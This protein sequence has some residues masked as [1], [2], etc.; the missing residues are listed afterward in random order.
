[1]SQDLT[2]YSEAK[3]ERYGE[4]LFGHV[5][6]TA[7]VILLDTVGDAP[8]LC[9][10]EPSS[11][12]AGMNRGYWQ[13]AEVGVTDLAEGEV[14]VAKDGDLSYF[15]KREVETV[16]GLAARGY[17]W[18]L[19]VVRKRTAKQAV[20][21]PLGT[22]RNWWGEGAG[23]N[24]SDYE[25]RWGASGNRTIFSTGKT[26][27]EFVN[28]YVAHAKHPRLT[29]LVTEA[30]AWDTEHNR[31]FRVRRE[32]RDNTLAPFTATVKMANTA[33][34]FNVLSVNGY[35][36][37]PKIERAYSFEKVPTDA[38]VL[39]LEARVLKGE[40]TTKVAEQVRKALTTNEVI[41]GG[42]DPEDDEF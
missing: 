42:Y 21:S 41:E 8:V 32:E 20:V 14:I 11:Y 27:A 23:V 35:G 30:K 19:Y 38:L 9:E 5:Q 26:L 1:M 33:L 36:D 24:V 37:Q 39:M 2:T 12:R 13:A 18:S 16:G 7:E 6:K 34:G 31:R 40:V 3:F 25:E 15:E 4:A 17:G 29:R 28:A 22:A 10:P